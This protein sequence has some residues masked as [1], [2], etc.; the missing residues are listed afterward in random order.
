MTQYCSRPCHPFSRGGA[1]AS[2]TSRSSWRR[3]ASLCFRLLLL[4]E[5]G[6]Q[7]HQGLHG[8][9][10]GTLGVD[11]ELT[12]AERHRRNVEVDPRQLFAGELAHEPGSRRGTGTGRTARVLEVGHFRLVEVTQLRP[13]GQVLVLL[14]DTLTGSLQL[15]REGVV[16]AEEP[17]S[18]VGVDLADG[19]GQGSDVDDARHARFTRVG[20]HVTQRQPALGVGVVHLHRDAAQHADAVAR[21]E[22][23]PA[24]HV[25]DRSHVGLDRDGQL[26]VGDRLHGRQH[27]AAAGHVALHVAHAVSRL[28][29]VATRV[30]A[31]GL[32]DVA[33]HFLG[34][35][36]GRGV[37]ELDQVVR[38]VGALAHV[39]DALSADDGQLLRVQ[40]LAGDETAGLFGNALGLV[41]ERR[42][43]ELAGRQVGQVARVVDRLSDDA[44]LGQRLA[45]LRAH[46]VL[47]EITQ[48]FQLR[49]R[50]VAQNADGLVVVDLVVDEER[51]G[52][53]QLSEL[54]CRHLRAGQ[55]RLGNGHFVD[56]LRTRQLERGGERLAKLGGGEFAALADAEEDGALGADGA[57]RI[58][59]HRLPDGTS[60]LFQ[61]GLRGD[62]ATSGGVDVIEEAGFRLPFESS[63]QKRVRVDRGETALS[64]V[65]L[66]DMYLTVMLGSAAPRQVVR[67]L[68]RSDE[69]WLRLRGCGSCRCFS[70]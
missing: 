51:N 60:E 46:L 63:D 23:A 21:L 49:T 43:S 7:L 10:R 50:R 66:H 58:A 34:G 65:E 31:D 41:D 2:P 36:G 35:A 52:G 5:L 38:L 57:E 68:E 9:A 39:D 30:E 33:E 13:H 20:D 42:R 67:R 70:R 19:A 44:P 62:V 45:H 1:G 40:H 17:G 16:V 47:G 59:Q 48:L 29:V 37:D 27:R 24:D 53:R 26:Q 12:V 18:H 15:T 32:A 64:C 56:L 14:A 28:Q 4:G 25:L 11:A 6:S 8:E 55:G 61:R 69:T 3:Y 54:G 22:G